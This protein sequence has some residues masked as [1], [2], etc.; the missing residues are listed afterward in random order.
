MKPVIVWYR[1][2]LRTYDYL[3]L[4]H[5][6]QTGQ[7]ILP[8]FIFDPTILDSKRISPARLKFMLN[9]LSALRDDLR[10]MGG[11]LYLAHGNP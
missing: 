9:G 10:Q 7:P 11:D 8:V 1:R 5:A 4:Y 3:P 2:D 6:I